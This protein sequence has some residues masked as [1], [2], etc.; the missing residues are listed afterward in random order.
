MKISLS[1]LVKTNFGH[2]SEWEGKSE[3]DEPVKISYRCGD[4]KIFLNDKHITTT[5]KDDLDIGG[6]M[7]DEELKQI[8]IRDELAVD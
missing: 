5:H 7:E 4:I 8:L 6:F 2:P 1:S 3:K